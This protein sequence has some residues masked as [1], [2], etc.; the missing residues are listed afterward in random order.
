[1][2]R[3]RT[4]GIIANLTLTSRFKEK[5]DVDKRG[6][7]EVSGSKQSD[8]GI[9]NQNVISYSE[10][11]SPRQVE[12]GSVA[13][14]VEVTPGNELENEMDGQPNQPHKIDGNNPAHGATN[15]P[16]N[17]SST[18]SIDISESGGP[19][20]GMKNLIERNREILIPKTSIPHW[21]E[22]QLDE[23]LAFD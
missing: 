12:Y 4:N 17:G 18:N 13:K 15:A 7:D 16:N 5:E 8:N 23:L 14:H 21:T 9:R 10:N 11:V 2:P 1:M 3:E 6:R 22:E 19:E 20:T